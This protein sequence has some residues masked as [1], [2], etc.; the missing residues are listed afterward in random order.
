[1]RRFRPHFRTC[2][3]Q[4]VGLVTLCALVAGTIGLPVPQFLW[5]DRSQPFPCQFSRCGCLDAESCWKSCCC[6]TNTEKLAWA[7]KHGVKPPAYVFAAAAQEQRTML[8]SAAKSCCCCSKPAADSIACSVE[9][10]TAEEQP[11]LGLAVAED[12][13]NC[14][15]QAALVL[16]LSQVV[17][18]RPKLDF[19]FQ[20]ALSGTVVH[21]SV[22]AESHVSEI[23]SPPPEVV[24]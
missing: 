21:F 5:K 15:G 10:A 23:E 17:C 9:P 19:D 18:E 12:M 6:H 16:M 1:M 20:P 8:T 7:R 14:K 13:R 2:V 3:R 24:L 22:T 4:A 11:W